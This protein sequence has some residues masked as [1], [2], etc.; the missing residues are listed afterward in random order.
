[1]TEL[2]ITIKA[3]ERSYKQKFLVY[4]EFIWSENDPVIQGLVKEALEN[5]KIEPHEDVNIKIRALIQYQ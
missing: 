4:E 1:M 5:A 2:Y 3:D